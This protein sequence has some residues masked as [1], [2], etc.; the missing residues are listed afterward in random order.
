MNVG[1][2]LGH[3]VCVSPSLSSS[4]FRSCCPGRHALHVVPLFLGQQKSRRPEA[5]HCAFPR[6]AA[7]L[8]ARRWTRSA[9]VWRPLSPCNSSAVPIR[10]KRHN[11]LFLQVLRA[12]AQSQVFVPELRF[13]AHISRKVRNICAAQNQRTI[14]RRGDRARLL[15]QDAR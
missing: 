9:H 7:L 12:E 15:R 5:R 10:G 11:F 13:S 2:R 14:E 4:S 8:S 1:S 3:C 6:T